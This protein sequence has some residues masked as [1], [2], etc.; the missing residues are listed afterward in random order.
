VLAAFIAILAAAG[1]PQC[2]A[3]GIDKNEGSAV[4][5]DETVEVE[6]TAGGGRRHVY[7]ERESGVLVTRHALPAGTYLGRVY[8][9]H[10]KIVRRGDHIR[11]SVRIGHAAVVRDATALQPA[12]AGAGFFVRTDD[13]A[14]FV[15]PPLNV[16]SEHEQ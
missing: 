13:G 9:A 6:C 4:Q 11:L 14:V 16:R 7:F 10:E 15:A 1:H 5:R 3:L 2:F 12:E 8:F